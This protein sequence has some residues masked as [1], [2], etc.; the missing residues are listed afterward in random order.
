MTA[1]TS[2]NALKVVDV[3]TH[4][5]EPYDLWTSRVSTNRWGDKVPHVAHDTTLGVDMW[6]SGG[7]RLRAAASAAQAG[8]SDMPPNHPPSLDLVAPALWRN[9]D[10]LALM[11][12]F[13]I[14][15]QVL[16]PNVAG[17][18]AGQF[19]ELND[20]TLA[21]E[22][23]RAYNDFLTEWSSIDLDRFIPVMAVPVWDIELS[24]KEM[25]RC[26]GLGH[27]GMIFSQSPD[28]FGAPRLGDPHWDRLWAAAQEM[29]LSVSFHIAS[30]DM[31]GT[32]LL[33][34]SSGPAAN[35]ATFPVTFF[36]DNCRAIAT[37]I[38]A[39]I[40]HR[41]P[42]LNFISVESG[43]GWLPF[44]VAALDWMWVECGVAKEHPEYDLLPS[45]YFKRQILG[46]FWFEA[47]PSIDSAIAAL[48]ADNLMYETDFPHPTSMWPGPVSTAVR[49]A[50]YISSSLGHLPSET[51]SK[52]VSGNAARIYHLDL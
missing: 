22:L 29:E 2:S 5:L 4:I 26:R 6:Y 23:L 36:V 45:E 15:A 21:L 48:G 47:A 18:G 8:W 46:C 19:T 27:R 3:D 43:I 52:L 28:A 50:E 7:R 13:G 51:I 1:I 25:E 16:Y 32:D 41:F 38:G 42:R 40:C 49:P 34:S 17:F 37:L 30:G 11:D 24:I 35:M 12:E 10:R 31:S 14:H 33:H 39:G 44:S 20:P 9:V